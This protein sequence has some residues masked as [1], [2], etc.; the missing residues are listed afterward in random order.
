ME[1][2]KFQLCCGDRAAHFASCLEISAGVVVHCRSG[3]DHHGMGYAESKVDI[4]IC[5]IQLSCRE[6]SVG[7]IVSFLS[8][9]NFQDFGKDISFLWNLPLA[10][11]V[12][13]GFKTPE[14]LMLR[15]EERLFV[16]KL[17]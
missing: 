6:V 3:M 8:V 5:E 13:H 9:S 17:Y 12:G 2:A 10:N 4:W 16:K 1:R 15:L 11:R 14:L 7:A